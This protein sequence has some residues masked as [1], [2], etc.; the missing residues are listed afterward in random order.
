MKENTGSKNKPSHIRSNHFWQ[1]IKSIYWR[2]RQSFQQM[3]LGKLDIHMHK[4]EVRSI[5]NIIHKIN[6]KW[7]LNLNVRPVTL[8]L[9]EEKRDKPSPL[10]LAVISWIWHQWHSQH[11]KI[12]K[13]DF[14][15]I[16]YIFHQNV[17]STENKGNPKKCEK[18]LENHVS[19]KR[20][21]SR[22][23]RE[24]LKL[25]NNNQK[26]NS[27]MSKGHKQT[28]FQRRYTNGQ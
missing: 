6:S 17:V 4:N 25:N 21:I 5:P 2:K 13:L 8:K 23:D 14:T 7:T 24:L 10:N 28:F 16:L 11:K 19:D 26:P 20:L 15:K 9:F 12:G 18:T 22:M 27:K 3:V 1:G